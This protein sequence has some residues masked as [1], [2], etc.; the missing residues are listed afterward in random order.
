MKNRLIALAGA[1]IIGL[2][3]ANATASEIDLVIGDDYYV[4]VVVPGIPPDPADQ[5]DY[6]TKLISLSTGTACGVGYDPCVGDVYD[7]STYS[8]I[9]STL[10]GV[11]PAPNPLDATHV[12]VNGAL[13]PIDVTGVSYVLAK[14]D[15]E[16]A[17]TLVWLVSGTNTV[18]IPTT[19]NDHGLSNYTIFG[20]TS[21]PDG[22]MTLML[23]GGALVGIG[24]LR[25]RTH[26]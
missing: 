5:T 24:A 15:A 19:F 8:R 2:I 7:Q 12:D 4:G 20:T 6:L 26:I 13:D 16:K 3:P 21:V 23:L 14:Y 17:G 10:A 22:G 9:D 11:L 18:T 25:R 1:L